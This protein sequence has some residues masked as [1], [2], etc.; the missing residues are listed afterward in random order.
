MKAKLTR[1]VALFWLLLFALYLA[2]LLAPEQ[3]GAIIDV[4]RFTPIVL[5]AIVAINVI[6][7]ILAP[8]SSEPERPL[9]EPSP[10]ISGGI[11]ILAT[12]FVAAAWLGYNGYEADGWPGLIL[13]L[14]IAVV[15][16]AIALAATRFATRHEGE[17][18][19]A[20][21]DTNNRS[22]PGA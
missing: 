8:R 15:T 11:V 6:I 7:T 18:G 1:L 4:N 2:M 22:Q 5:I 20:R 12:G 14:V 10:A 16:V 21:F 17:I 13:P 19:E 3:L 9:P